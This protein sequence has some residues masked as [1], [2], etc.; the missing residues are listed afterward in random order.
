MIID[1]IDEIKKDEPLYNKKF[2]LSKVKESIDLFKNP[3]TVQ[4]KILLV[5]ENF[6]Q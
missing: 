3:K 1:W 5:N 2:P 6:K 4:G